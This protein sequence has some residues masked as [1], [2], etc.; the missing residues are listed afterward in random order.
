MALQPW[1]DCI[2]ACDACARACDHCAAACLDEPDVQ[3]MRRCI[4]LDMDCAAICRYAA[5]A[6]ARDSEFAMQMCGV[7]AE[8][9]EACGEECGRHP[10]RALPGLRGGVQALR[11]RL[12]QHVGAAMTITPQRRM[13]AGHDGPIKT[14]YAFGAPLQHSHRS[15][16][17]GPAP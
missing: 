2:E 4:A 10:A 13:P 14:A 15:L 6:M 16:S 17:K 9:C 5:G 7:C 1:A 8:I 12:P 11:D 3:A